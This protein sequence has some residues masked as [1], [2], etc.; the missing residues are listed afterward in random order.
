MPM[1]TE[2]LTNQISDLQYL[3]AAPMVATVQ[4][5]IYAAK[6]FVEFIEEYGFEEL[7]FEEAN[8]AGNDKAKRN[9]GKL[10]MITFWYTYNQVVVKDG[11]ETTIE[12]MVSVSLPSISMV[13]MPLLQVSDAQYN[14]D[15]RITGMYTNQ[16][17]PSSEE[18]NLMRTNETIKRK[19]RDKLPSVKATYTPLA[20][21]TTPNSIAPSLMANMRV[22]INMR[23]ADI[24]AGIS[25]LLNIVTES[26]N[27][28]TKLV[29][30]DTINDNK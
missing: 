28:S 18:G 3:I 23:Q 30:T 19:K 24:P 8:N 16:V 15:I 27:S 2:V 25:N 17:I 4:A 21:E 12:K 22:K 26:N 7:L 20:S 13:P 9:L 11:K 10:K 6:A 1:A 5:D 14:F 29:P